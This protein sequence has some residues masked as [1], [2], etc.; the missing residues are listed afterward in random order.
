[1]KSTE[2]AYP[3]VSVRSTLMLILWP[4]FLTA[5]VASGV[6]FSLINPEQLIL[7]DDRIQLSNLGIYSSGFFV[8][9][10][11]GVIS[12]GLTVLLSTNAK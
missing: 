12:S 9:W 2:A 7:L 5:C 10:L 1:M 8:F 11:L 3:V 4:S 6:L